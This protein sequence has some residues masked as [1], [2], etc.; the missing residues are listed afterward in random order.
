MSSNYLSISPDPGIDLP[1]PQT[2]D[3][4]VQS[5]VLEAQR[6]YDWINGRDMSLCPD[7]IAPGIPT[8]YFA[9]NVLAP[10]YDIEYK[11]VVSLEATGAAERTRWY[12]LVKCYSLPNNRTHI[13]AASA[14]HSIIAVYFAWRNAIRQLI[15]QEERIAYRDSSQNAQRRYA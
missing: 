14:K 10:I 8:T 2:G 11:D 13:G 3:K 9:I 12:A 4:F 15:P 6:V 7:W 1:T 5:E